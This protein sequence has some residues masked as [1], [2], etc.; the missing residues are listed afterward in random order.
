[1]MGRPLRPAPMRAA[2]GSAVSQIVPDKQ[3]DE[4]K[5]RETQ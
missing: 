3:F 4:L 1:M 2:P 5:H